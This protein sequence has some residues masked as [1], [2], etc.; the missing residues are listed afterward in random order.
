MFFNDNCFFEFCLF[1]CFDQSSSG[2]TQSHPK[3]VLPKLMNNYV[4]AVYPHVFKRWL[5]ALSIIQQRQLSFCMAYKFKSCLSPKISFTGIY[6]L[7]FFMRISSS[8]VFPFT[9]FYFTVY[10]YY[11]YYEKSSSF[12]YLFILNFHCPHFQIF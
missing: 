12:T 3:L 4:L 10:Y 9:F 8:K 7:C 6:S 5:F 1:S 11:H 2:D